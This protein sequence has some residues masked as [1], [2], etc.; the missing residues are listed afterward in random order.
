MNLTT[1][2]SLSSCPSRQVC[3]H[4]VCEEYCEYV[5]KYEEVYYPPV[6]EYV[7]VPIKVRRCK[8]D[9]GLKALGFKL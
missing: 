6:V 7:E 9:P 2:D 4:H 1:F 5:P 8:L 3:Y